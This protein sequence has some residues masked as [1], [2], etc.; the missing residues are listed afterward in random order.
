MAKEEPDVASEPP[1]IVVA[2]VAV[3][4]EETVDD[5]FATT[6]RSSAKWAELSAVWRAAPKADSAEER[7]AA[8]SEPKSVARRSRFLS[9]DRIRSSA[10]AKKPDVEVEVCRYDSRNRRI[11]DLRIPDPQG[12]LVSLK[13]FDSD[14]VLID[15][16]GTWCRPCLNSIP[17]LTELQ[18]KLGSKR[19]SILGIACEEGPESSSAAHVAD[20]AKSLGIN[21]TVGVSSKDGRSAIQEALQIQA[22]PTMVVVDREGRIIWRDQGAT[23]VTL[24]RLDRVLDPSK[25]TASAFSMPDRVRR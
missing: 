7:T 21:Y 16:W 6:S 24:A 19:V 15:F 13:D 2:S 17:H 14:Y 5:P 3:P 1:A 22:Y 25:R 9:V 12:R 23:E 8:R 11:L 20:V 18:S 10:S 4:R